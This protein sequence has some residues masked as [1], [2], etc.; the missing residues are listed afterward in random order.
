VP[1][2]KHV[3]DNKIG[4]FADR[5]GTR[6]QDWRHG[7]LH[8]R[9]RGPEELRDLLSEPPITLPQEWVREVNRPQS[10]AEQATMVE[11]IRRGPAVRAGQMGA[12]DGRAVQSAKHPPPAWAAKGLEEAERKSRIAPGK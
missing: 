1:W 9:L 3:I 11:C 6:A 5:R 10:D 12:D 8:V 7:S 2:A 4:R